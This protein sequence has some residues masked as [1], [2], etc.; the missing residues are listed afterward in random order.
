[1]ANPFPFV[2]GSVLQAAELNGIGEAATTFTPNL[3]GYTRGN[4]TSVAGH[5][6]VNKLVYLF[7]RETLGSTSSLTGNLSLTLPINAVSVERLSGWCVLGDTGVAAYVGFI[8]P[9]SSSSVAIEA[10]NAAGTYA[11]V[12][13]ISST[14][15]FTWGNTDFIQ[16]ALT[17]EVA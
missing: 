9:V 7:L 10:I 13:A 11:A 17:Y 8:R 15:P 5:V 2:A 16:I 14:V 1:M 12:A 3:T 6:R 4:G